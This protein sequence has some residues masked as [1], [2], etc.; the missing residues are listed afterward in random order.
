MSPTPFRGCVSFPFLCSWCR[1]VAPGHRLLAGASCGSWVQSFHLSLLV[2]RSPHGTCH[3]ATMSRVPCWSSSSRGPKVLCMARC[4]LRRFLAFVSS[5]LRDLFLVMLGPWLVRVLFR[6]LSLPR[7]GPLCARGSGSRVAWP[8]PRPLPAAL[9]K[10]SPCRL[11][12]RL[13]P[14]RCCVRF[15]WA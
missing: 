3:A 9:L 1:G 14:S 6:G 5:A 4:A 10:F 11:L 12:A 2:L 7:C 13:P 15:L 8:C